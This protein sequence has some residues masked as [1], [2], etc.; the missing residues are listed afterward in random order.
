MI[1]KKIVITGGPCA[2]K[3]TAM[4]MLRQHFSGKGY[5]VYMGSETAT[6]LISGGVAPWILG[7]PAFQTAVFSLQKA[8]EDAIE[9]AARSMETEKVLIVLD[10]GLL[11]GKA[12][13][14]PEEYAQILEENGLTEEEINARYDGVFHLVTAA[15][16]ARDY[17]T[18]ANNATR[19]ETVEEAVLLDRRTAEVWM[20]HPNLKIID[21]STGFAEKMTR[22]LRVIEETVE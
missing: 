12:Y 21:N 2:G 16:G 14:A 15:N 1:V 7:I 3:T 9:R 4:D 5:R 10:R 18:L 22:L 8:K 19:T 17:Y 6:D 20:K 11:D 13:M